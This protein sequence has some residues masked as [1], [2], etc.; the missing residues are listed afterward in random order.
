VLPKTRPRTGGNEARISTAVGAPTGAAVPVR[1]YEGLYC[2]APDYNYF[3]H[4]YYGYYKL[5]KSSTGYSIFTTC[6]DVDLD[7]ANVIVS[8]AQTMHVHVQVQPCNLARNERFRFER[9]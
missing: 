9:L 4:L 3:D 7:V 1:M 6:L 5:V 2:T 8:S